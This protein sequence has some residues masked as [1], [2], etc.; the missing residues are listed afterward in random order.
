MGNS[1]ACLDDGF[2][3]LDHSG[4]GDLTVVNHARISLAKHKEVMDPGDEKLVDFLMRNRHGTPF[5]AIQF[6]FHVRAPIFVTREWMRHRIASY[7]EMSARYVKMEQKFY[8][9]QGA[10]IRTQ[11]GKAG[12]YKFR[13]VDNRDEEDAV[14]AEMR[15]CYEQCSQTYQKLLDMGIAREVARDVLPVSLYTEF[16]FDVNARS[17]MNFISLRSGEHA[18]SEI[19]VYAHALER[20]FAQ[21]APVCYS[22]FSK[23]GRVA[24]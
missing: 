6:S 16:Y 13:S 11:E 15:A 19:R 22:C 7:N 4:G 17:L 12:D 18:L 2:V 1:I 5:E 23:N 24:P 3:R 8:L 20:F 14:R 10:M 21:V 9:P